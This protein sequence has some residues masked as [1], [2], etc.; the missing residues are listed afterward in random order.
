MRV[1]SKLIWSSA[2]AALVSGVF[3]GLMLSGCRVPDT[4]IVTNTNVEYVVAPD[5]HATNSGT[6]AS[7][8]ATLEQARNALR[9]KVQAGALP[10]GGF[11]IWL[12][13]GLYARTNTFELTASDSGTASS[14]ITYC[15]WPNESVRIHGAQSLQPAWFTPVTSSS[16]VW[17]RLDPSA[18]ANILQVDLAAH[19]IKDYGVLRNRGFGSS[20][21]IG[22]L[23]LVFDGN[24][25]Q[26]A[27][28][29]DVGQSDV[30]A[31]NGWAYTEMPLSPTNFTYSG[32][33]PSRWGQAEELWIHSFLG[34]H[35]ADYHLKPSAINTATRTV[36]FS[37]APN[38]G[39]AKHMPYYAENLL[40]EITRPGEWYVNR[41]TGILYFF[42]PVPLD[43]HELQLSMLE[44]PLVRLIDTRH[45]IWR[46][47]TFETVRGDLLAIKGGEY[48]R[49]I[50]CLLRN[51]GNYAAKISNGTRNGFSRC[52]IKDTGDGGIMMSGGNRK[53]LT[54]AGNYVRNCT[55]HGFG[56]FDWMCT[57]AVNFQGVGQIVEHNLIYDSPHTAI[58]FSEGNYNTV[59][60]NEVR[61]VCKWSSDAGSIY[62][63]RDLAAHGS[64]IG[65][66]FVHHIAGQFG[67]GVGYG[68]HGIYLDDCIA[69]IEVFGNICYEVSGMGIQ[70]GSGRDDLM[71]NNV[72]VKCGRAMGPDTRGLTW[73]MKPTWEKAQALPYRSTIWSNAFPQ[74]V[75]MPT[76]WVTVTNS[77]WL[78]PRN[79]VF[80]R[81]I[82]F[83]NTV[84]VS[85]LK[86][87]TYFAEFANNLTNSDPR[88]VDESKLN[89]TL[90]SDSPA[91]TIPG[92][93]NIPFSRIGPE[94]ATLRELASWDFVSATNRE[95]FSAERLTAPSSLTVNNMTATAAPGHPTWAIELPYADMNATSEAGAFVSNDSLEVTVTPMVQNPFSVAT[96]AFSHRKRGNGAGA[97]LFLRSSADGYATTL[98]T[99][100]L[101][102]ANAWNE[103]AFTLSSIAPLQNC[104]KP[105]TLRLYAYKPVGDSGT[106]RL[107]LDNIRVLGSCTDSRKPTR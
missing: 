86:A 33:R 64:I 27:R 9:V 18:R 96:F 44:V 13:G 87:T 106:Q 88:F 98:G 15:A 5:G 74:L 19:G 54:G 73:N 16:P 65:Y 78:A 38:Y 59:A 60:F 56:R 35:W 68:T 11:T 53:T 17:S 1:Q 3:Y 63:G 21:T 83:S 97:T 2:S 92:F 81:N 89:M 80:S 32:S 34:N 20:A 61:D 7:P 52:E 48:N 107:S 55:I 31:K 6:F 67:K 101:N 36:N 76:N 4:Q 62:T 95:G 102:G 104:S 14:P 50:N 103:T 72:L 91:F 100:T 10:G 46:D 45:V 28:W 26:L 43:N 70:H 69:G 75:A 85:G 29:P 41:A 94:K 30:E 22:A 99:V 58:L 24:V 23:E 49:V 82:G 39:I 84:W 42:P 12:R 105:V 93:V 37:V 90:R 79:T 57:P 8:F 51:P 47:I 77:A 66:N 71:V 40:E 25:Q